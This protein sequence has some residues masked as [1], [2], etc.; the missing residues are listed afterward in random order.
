MET[1][2]QKVAEAGKG[3][4]GS[5]NHSGAKLV[6]DSSDMRG[7]LAPKLACRFGMAAEV[8]IAVAGRNGEGGLDMARKE[9]AT[10]RRALDDIK[11][12]EKFGIVFRSG[13]HGG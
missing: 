1:G 7:H 12:T 9:A 10:Q 3:A 11:R 4:A 6:R 5:L 8:G 13:K 2:T